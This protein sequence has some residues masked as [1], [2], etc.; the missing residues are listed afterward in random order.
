MTIKGK[1]KIFF[2]T[3]FTQSY[4]SGDLLAMFLLINI[5]LIYE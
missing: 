5:E 4:T 1:I 3:N 2:K